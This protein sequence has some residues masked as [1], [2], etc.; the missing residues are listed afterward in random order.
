MLRTP[1]IIFLFSTII[2]SCNTGDAKM[3][4]GLSYRPGEG[5]PAYNGYVSC[6]AT[7]NSDEYLVCNRQS[8]VVKCGYCTPNKPLSE[9][10][11]RYNSK[12]GEF[13]DYASGCEAHPILANPGG[14]GG[15]AAAPLDS[16]NMML[17]GYNIH[18][19]EKHHFWAEKM[20]D[21]KEFSY[22]D[23][24]KSAYMLQVLYSTDPNLDA[25]L[26]KAVALASR[27]QKN[28][29]LIVRLDYSGGNSNP[30][31]E[32]LGRYFAV[33]DRILANPGVAFVQAGNEPNLRG[34]CGDSIDNCR[35]SSYIPII[36][37]YKDDLR[38]ISAPW[39]TDAN[40]VA[41]YESGEDAIPWVWAPNVLRG[42]CPVNIGI[43]AYSSLGAG[44]RAE[45]FAN[46]LLALN[47][48]Y[49][50]R[51]AGCTRS[52]IFITEL[53]GNMYGNADEWVAAIKAARTGVD[54]VNNKVG[55]NVIKGVLLFTLGQEN[56]TDRDDQMSRFM[57][58]IEGRAGPAIHT[59]KLC[60]NKAQPAP[61]ECFD[62]AIAGEFQKFWDRWILRDGN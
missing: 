28:D 1:I 23:P 9:Y 33:I 37:R 56:T 20:G 41:K 26:A 51:V 52:N 13:D 7:I 31:P 49:I 55:W 36:E 39:A 17:F 5:C 24:G 14:T 38:F 18:D 3:P 59:A 58:A 4:S 32:N 44:N 12:T 27:E 60:G 21:G 42:N 62:P 57:L 16:S 34:E 54:W 35:W 46:Q 30:S 53:N 2:F 19:V 45:N 48:R 29:K 40:F 47:L 50:R 8:K 11:A 22:K 15:G 25:T 61:A 10:D 43:H 6:I